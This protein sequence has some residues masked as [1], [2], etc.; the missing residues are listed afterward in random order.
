VSLQ[1]H[2]IPVRESLIEVKMI[3]ALVSTSKLLLDNK[4]GFKE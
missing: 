4:I 1:A 2:L 3:P